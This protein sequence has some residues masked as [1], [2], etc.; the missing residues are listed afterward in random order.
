MTTKEKCKAVMN[1]YAK[2]EKSPVKRLCS[3]NW[4]F[5]HNA[6][7]LAPSKAALTEQ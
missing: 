4:G 7:E 6:N 3:Q 2:F 1:I 5:I